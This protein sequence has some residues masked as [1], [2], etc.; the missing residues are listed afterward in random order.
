MG[1]D[2]IMQSLEKFFAQV[3]WGRGRGAVWMIL[4]GLA[5]VVFWTT[6]AEMEQ[7]PTVE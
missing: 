6:K 2:A 7:R 3:F 4:G 1:P 5:P